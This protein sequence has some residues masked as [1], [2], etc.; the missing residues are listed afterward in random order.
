MSYW[1]ASENKVCRFGIYLGMAF[2]LTIS[3]RND[4]KYV[5]LK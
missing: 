3:N 5:K 4:D 2:K 1:H